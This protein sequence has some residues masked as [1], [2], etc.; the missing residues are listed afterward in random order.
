MK[1]CPFS[2]FSKN[3][4]IRQ[5]YNFFSPQKKFEF[6]ENLKINNFSI[7]NNDD[8]LNNSKRKLYIPELNNVKKTNF[9]KDKKFNSENYKQNTISFFDKN[10][11][12]TNYFNLIEI[13]DNK[14]MHKINSNQ[15]DSKQLKIAN[16][17]NDLKFKGFLKNK[18]NFREK[19]Q[20]KLKNFS[21]RKL[22]TNNKCPFKNETIK[23]YQEI[24]K[25]YKNSLTFHQK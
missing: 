24:L 7:H 13:G 16:E 3:I 18:L 10:I 12:N 23:D 8:N 1:T 17:F 15:K 20:G 5:K 6:H 9:E 14:L 11:N 19:N 4:N 22:Q 2:F 25:N 21:P